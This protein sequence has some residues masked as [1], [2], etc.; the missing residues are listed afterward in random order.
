MPENRLL[1]LSSLVAKKSQTNLAENI[2]AN[3]RLI[4]ERH[5]IQ[6]D[7]RLNDALELD[8]LLKTSGE[9]VK[10]EWQLLLANRYLAFADL[11]HNKD[12][13]AK[14]DAYLTER[15]AFLK[16]LDLSENNKRRFKA[17]LN[18]A[19]AYLLERCVNQS[20]SDLDGVFLKRLLNMG[21]D[22]KN[23][24]VNAFS[25]VA[26]RQQHSFQK[27]AQLGLQRQSP[28]Q[29]PEPE[30][31]LDSDL[32]EFV[33]Q[34]EV[35]QLVLE[36]S[37][38]VFI[39]TKPDTSNDAAIARACQ[40]FDDM[41]SAEELQEWEDRQYALKLHEELQQDMQDEE[42]ALR[43][44]MLPDTIDREELRLK[45]QERKHEKKLVAEMEMAEEE[46]LELSL[47]LELQEELELEANEMTL[48]YFGLFAMACSIELSFTFIAV[49]TQALVR[50][51]AVVEVQ[52]VQTMGLF[53]ICQQAMFFTAAPRPSPYNNSSVRPFL[54]EAQQPGLFGNQ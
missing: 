52:A 46:E 2:A 13:R 19:D 27:M 26:P 1:D 15:K 37:Q 14:Y 32:P 11:E 9:Q 48:G 22:L 31:D 20:L 17:T 36:A 50:P 10:K 29:S 16:R 51:A 33:L 41:D 12:N 43:L 53:A 49:Q 40:E 18:R 45:K 23:I 35:P 5:G 38:S 6:R 44:S 4:D 24:I 21:S 30:S 47:G 3:L 54:E 42:Y 39:D 8:A 28:V 25:K 7:H 34:P